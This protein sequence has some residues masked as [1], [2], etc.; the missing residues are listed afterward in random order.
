VRKPIDYD[1]LSSVVAKIED[2]WFHT[3][4]LPPAP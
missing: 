2:F 4:T 1:E 3:V